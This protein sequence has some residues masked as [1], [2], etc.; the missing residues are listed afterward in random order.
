MCLGIFV[1]DFG[2]LMEKLWRNLEWV[3][4]EQELMSLE[5]KAVAVTEFV[6]VQR[7]FEIFA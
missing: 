3:M 5:R 4:S 2:N 1:V 6:L 7:H